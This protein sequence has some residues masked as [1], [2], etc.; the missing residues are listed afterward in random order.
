M[1]SNVPL[2]AASGS[3]PAPALPHNCYQ[4]SSFLRIFHKG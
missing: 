3:M 1:T 4:I 2:A